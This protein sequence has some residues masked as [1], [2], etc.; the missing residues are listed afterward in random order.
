MY[1]IFIFLMIPAVILSCRKRSERENVIVDYTAYVDPMIG[2]GGHG[3]TY[4]GATVPFGMVQI[5]PDN[6]KE[7]W[8]WCSGYH[9]SSDTIAGFTHTHLSGTGIG[10]LLDIQVL[11]TTLPVDFSQSDS[12]GI[13]ISSYYAT[14]SHEDEIASPGYYSVVLHEPEIKAEFTATERAAFHRYNSGSAD[15]ISIFVNPGFDLNYD[16]T[17]Q[18]HI[19]IVSDTL[20]SGFKYS[21]GWANNQEVYFAMRFSKPIAS[22]YFFSNDSLQLKSS[23]GIQAQH[24][25]GIFKF[26]LTDRKPLLI[27]VGLSSVSEENALSNLNYEMP[28]WNFNKIRRQA[29]KSWN[30][31]L[32]K[33]RVSSSDVSRLRIF[34]TA[35]Y[36][37]M[38]A[39]TIYSDSIDNN[40]F[41]YRSQGNTVKSDKGFCN[42]YTF[43]LWDTYRAA[44]P[45]FTII[46]PARVQKFVLAMMAHYRDTGLLPVWTLWGNETNTMIG[47]H[48][49]PVIVD[50]YL[51]GLL[52]DIPVDSIY[53]A[54]LASADQK[55]RNV[56]LYR[57][58]GY[59]PSDTINNTV[60]MTLE[61]AFDDWCIAQMAEKLGHT[62]DAERFTKRS[63]YY[64][65][66]F[67]QQSRFMRAKLADGT[68][69]KPFDP[70][71]A[72][73]DNDY[74]EGNAWQ[75]TWYVPQDISSLINLMGGK[76]LFIS[77]LDSLFTISSSLDTNAA[78]DVSG[79]IGQYVH[80]NEPSHDIPYLYNYAGQPWKTQERVREIM[81]KMYSDQPDGLCGND[82]CGQMSAWYVF[83]A[84]G[85]Y[86]VNPANGR[87]DLGIPLFP[88]VDIRLPDNKVFSI[89]ANNLNEKNL[90]VKS[91]KLNGTPLDSLFIL[92]NQIMPG[93]TLTF[94]MTDQPVK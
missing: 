76:T 11:P 79:M 9:Y 63:G 45:L 81:R 83:N 65:N 44:H 50:A 91:V 56:P 77:K 71:N 23:Y 25:T 59:I 18:S 47:Y 10:D 7:G 73:Y 68:W 14:F 69:E 13:N 2:T 38:L 12:S 33:I 74:T 82:D 42:F 57:Q 72:G 80:G 51:K 19:K 5:S 15:T 49:V 24:A 37:F 62:D 48:A 43:S 30:T 87:Y 16:S 64:K 92:H 60:S 21:T 54:L 17:I 93:G 20:V 8:D 35:L 85:F 58:F 36:H 29:K 75:Y 27:K 78:I 84:L 39:P 70:L 4:P 46:Q 86:P 32:G 67:D 34:Y 94:D 90:Y 52:P 31:E 88:R 22:Y 61:Y 3:H 26:N 55:I 89:I 1:R 40:T 53:Q 28:D 6:G 41:Q 66:V